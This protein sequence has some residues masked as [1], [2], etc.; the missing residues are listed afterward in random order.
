MASPISNERAPRAG[1]GRKS[2]S[3]SAQ[4]RKE[5]VMLHQGH[6]SNQTNDADGG[7]SFWRSRTGLVFASFLGIALFLLLSEHWA[8]ALG[9]LLHVFMHSGHGGHG[10]HKDVKG[11]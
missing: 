5:K 1:G 11:D 3:R 6:Q 2:N 4:A 8:H 9:L 10:N 7:G